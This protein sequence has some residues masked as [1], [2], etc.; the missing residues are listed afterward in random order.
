MNFTGVWKE[1]KDSALFVNISPEEKQE[2]VDFQYDI[3]TTALSCINNHNDLVTKMQAGEKI[4]EK[5]V[6]N[7]HNICY[8]AIRDITNK[9]VSEKM[10]PELK[11]SCLKT[12]DDFKKVVVN[13]SYYKYSDTDKQ[14]NVI[15]RLK[16]NS[17]ILTN[18]VN[19][20]AKKWKLDKN[21]LNV[22]N[23]VKF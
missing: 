19:K 10:K 7:A 14:E 13:I 17:T 5:D 4:S 21:A 6:K 15:K 9:N 22:E 8:A 1:F 20:N 23:L 12:K 3:Y 16:E 2:F 18:D 11:T